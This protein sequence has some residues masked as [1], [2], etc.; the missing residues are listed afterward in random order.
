M[1]FKNVKNDDP[2]CRQIGLYKSR[3]MWANITDHLMFDKLCNFLTI[4]DTIIEINRLGLFKHYFYRIFYLIK[5]ICQIY[6]I[7]Q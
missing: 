7:Q 4:S 3:F 6:Q 1:M 2:E 5:E